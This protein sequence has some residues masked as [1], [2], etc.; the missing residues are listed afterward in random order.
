MPASEPWYQE[1]LDFGV[2]ED[3]T[4]YAQ[5]FRGNPTNPDDPSVCDGSREKGDSWS[6][7]SIVQHDPR[8]VDLRQNQ[9]IRKGKRVNQQSYPLHMLPEVLSSIDPRLNSYITQSEFTKPNRRV[10]NLWR[11]GV[12]WLDMDTYKTPWGASRSLETQ[13]RDMLWIL[14]DKGYPEPSL[15]MSSGRGL[16]I[17]WF[18]EGL[19]RAALPRWNAVMREITK[20]MAEW[21]SDSAAKDASRVLRVTGTINSKSGE[22]VKVLHMRPDENGLPVR[23]SFDYLSE[24][25]LPLT[26]EQAREKRLAA[27]ARRAEYESRRAEQQARRGFG[28]GHLSVYRDY[29]NLR[30][31]SA[32]Q[33]AWD[34][35]EDL[36]RLVNLRQSSHSGADTGSCLEGYRELML[37][38]Q[39]NHLL[40]SQQVD[41]RNFWKESQALATELDAEWAQREGRN[42]LGTLFTKAKAQLNG[43]KVEFNGKLWNPLYTPRNQTLIDAF[44]ITPDEERQMK[45]IISQ[46]VAME[47]ARAR[48]QER[49]RTMRRAMGMK[50]Q[51]VDSLREQ[52]VDLVKKQGMSYRVAAQAVDVDPKTVWNWCHKAAPSE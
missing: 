34:R 32:Q 37:F 25:F 14:A 6:W 38:W 3:Y 21:G 47:R 9:G 27:I 33:L 17:K 39:M 41:L 5:F 48:D 43:E 11:V 13:V 1:Y 28:Q 22:L 49:K 35:V 26:R 36:R 40:L 51:K 20:E 19:P 7:F 16:Y 15:I 45:T 23:Y 52:A 42:T 31:F 10:V 46:S 29:P 50:A 18:H 30:P 24:Y 8:R 4:E 44:R 2:R 12:L